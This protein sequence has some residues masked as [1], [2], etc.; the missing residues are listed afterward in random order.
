MSKKLSIFLLV[1]FIVASCFLIKIIFS[2]NQTVISGA[3]SYSES[4]ENLPELQRPSWFENWQ[5]PE[6][7]AKIALQVGH[8]KNNELPD[9]LENLKVSSGSSG[10]GKSEWEVNLAIA[11]ETAKI[12]K[13]KGVEVEILPA[14]IPPSYWADVFV[15]I[16][17][18]GSTDPSTS[19]FKI[20][21]PWR[22]YTGKAASLVSLLENSYQEVTGLAKDPNVTRQMRGYY[23]FSWW[24][25]EHAIHPMTT[26]VIIETGFLTNRPDRKLLIATPEIAGQGIA[27]G[28]LKYLEGQNLLPS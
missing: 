19:G 3:P 25:Y 15:A 28:I 9:E 14:T 13:Q 17:A 11:E 1:A 4:E 22:D 12:L 10:G 26:A 24:R 2:I 21:A 20:A 5:R 6:G 16:H 7:P 23:A 27:Q 8:W 18:D